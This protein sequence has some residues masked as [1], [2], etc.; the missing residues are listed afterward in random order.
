[1]PVRC[2]LLGAG[3]RYVVALGSLCALDGTFDVGGQS[4]L[5]LVGRSILGGVGIR[6]VPTFRQLVGGSG[7]TLGP[8]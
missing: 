5:L 1:M 3:P 7:M 8:A 4:A 2:P 6:G